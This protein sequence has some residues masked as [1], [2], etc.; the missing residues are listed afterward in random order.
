MK[1][2]SIV[3]LGVVV[4]LAVVIAA[5]GETSD[6]DSTTESATAGTSKCGT[7]PEL[8][9]KGES[10]LIEGLGE[11]YQTNYNGYADTVFKS[12][13]ASFKP[14]G[15]G[16]YTIGVSVTQPISPFQGLLIPAL[17]KE[18]K[19][20]DGVGKLTIL[21]SGPTA[22]TTQLQQ[23]NQLIQQGVDIIV[24]EPLAGPPFAKVADVAGKAGIPMI[25]LVNATPSKY[26][27]DLASNSVGDAAH[28]G[29]ELA[30]LIGGKGTVLGVHGI[31]ST[32]VDQQSFAGWKAAFALCP[33]I[34][35]D[36]SVEGQFQ[37]A[38]AKAQVLSYLS[39]HPQK[40][41]GL[42]ETGGMTAGII[43]A[44]EQSGRP[45]PAT[46]DAGPSKG[47][48]AYWRNHQDEGYKAVSYNIAADGLAKATAD[49]VGRLL[50]GHGPKVSDLVQL[51]VPITA[52]NIDEFV[53]AG[54][55]E[56]DPSFVEPPAGSYFS[57]SYLDPLFN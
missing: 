26:A 38:L 49:V 42:V 15:D 44:F 2:Q 19:A 9:I 48:L 17:E 36:D 51:S 41:A 4:A 24:S 20:V 16:P 37:P 53:P 28:S 22:L 1:K 12:P 34:K 33:D 25:S 40:V 31:R 57:S 18:L 11:E 3:L 46:V 45:V 30:K 32:A 29:A 54:T 55:K 50:S 27:I 35:F 21:T 13:W 52:E 5:C 10:G 14:K 23:T 8:R 56:T 6:D 39:S 47:S 7:V 43:Q